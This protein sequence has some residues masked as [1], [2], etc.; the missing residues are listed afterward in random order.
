MVP[1]AVAQRW[2]LPH[3]SIG[4]LGP[5]QWLL[6]QDDGRNIWPWGLLLHLFPGDEPTKGSDTINIGQGAL[7]DPIS[8]KT[9]QQLPHEWAIIFLLDISVPKGVKTFLLGYLSPCLTLLSQII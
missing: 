6:A 3:Q 5:T 2:D 7:T 4:S 1:T 9:G 8:A